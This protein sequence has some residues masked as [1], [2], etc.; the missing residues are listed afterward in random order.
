MPVRVGL[1]LA[2]LLLTGAAGWWVQGLRHDLAEARAAVRGYEEAAR[3]HREALKKLAAIEADRDR[4]Q[5]MVDELGDDADAPLADS[6][7]GAAGRVWQ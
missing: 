1:I 4:L 7:R 3:V 2:A 6:V 5:S